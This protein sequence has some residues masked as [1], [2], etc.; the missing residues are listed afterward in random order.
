MSWNELASSVTELVLTCVTP[1]SGTV[2]IAK[3]DAVKLDGNYVVTNAT[4]DEDPVFGQAATDVSE[5]EGLIPVKVRG[6]CV[7]SYT[8]ASA[9][10]VDGAAGVVASDTA[11][12]VKKPASGNGKGI[13][14][15]VDTVGNRVYV[16][17]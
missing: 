10:V 7:F 2:A 15:G 11:G 13:N 17:L 3:G 14:L 16:L 1:N 9:P 12:K 5:T 4:S 6:V 8:G